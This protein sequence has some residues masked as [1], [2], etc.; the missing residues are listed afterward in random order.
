MSDSELIMRVK[1]K[2]ND[3]LQQL[4][5]RYKPVV[6]KIKAQYY[7]RNYDYQDWD[8]EAMIVCYE[9]CCLYD[10][11][12][13]SQFGAFYK[14]KFTNHVRSLLRYEL[15]KRREANR[16]A[17]SYEYGNDTGIIMEKFTN[18]YN[19]PISEIYSQFL[20]NLSELELLSILVYLGK[21]SHQQACKIG[22]CDRLK[23]LQAKARCKRKLKDEL[24]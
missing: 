3:A 8:Q 17:I 5:V 10:F 14:T 7:V 12:R 11:E 21:L 23:L 20:S 24:F 9:A 19:L 1:Q 13:N 22:R 15:A 16:T 4:F 6:N 2:D 18:D